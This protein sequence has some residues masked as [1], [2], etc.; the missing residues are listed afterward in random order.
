MNKII[1]QIRKELKQGCDP[2][3]KQGEIKFFKE[4]IKTYGTRS[5][6]TKKIAQKYWN[7]IKH[8]DKKQIFELAEELMKSGYIQ[9]IGIGTSWAGKLRKQ[10]TKQDF[11]VFE[12]WLKK[13]ISNWANCDMFCTHALAYLITDFPE[14][15]PR[16][17]SWA[18]SK[19]RWVKR[20][21][22]V[23]LI[24]PVRKEKKY[25]NK[26]FEIA[27]ILLLDQDD[28][29]Q[30]GYGWMLKEASNVY[31]KQ[32]FNYVI[33]NKHNMPRTSLR[34]AIEKMPESM[35]KTAMKK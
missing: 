9:E 5:P 21:S 26:I 11:K 23:I 29:V 16:L 10:Y 7:Q 4:P 13:Y 6:V 31:Q 2:N 27:N 17:N 35:R 12:S 34:Y 14:F 1:S 30:K 8:L 28:M 32:V 18:K 19:N 24:Y 15:L 33:K 20:A 22:A 3:Y 25:L